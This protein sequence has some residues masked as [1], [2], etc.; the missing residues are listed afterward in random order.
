MT[1]YLTPHT[2]YD[3]VWAFT[4]EDY[5][6]IHELILRKAVEMI[7]NCGYKFLVEQAFLLE[8]I[9]QRDPELFSAIRE[10][11][12]QGK[13]EIVDGQ[14]IMADP[15]IPDGEVL[16]RE[17]MTGKRY[18]K[19]KFG[20]DV[21]VAWASDG[22]GLNAQLP[23]I[24]KKCGYRWLAFR[25]GLPST[26]GYRVSEFLWE[27]LD[28]TQIL[29]HWMPLG[30]RAGMDLEKWEETFS[31]LSALATTDNILM[32]CGSGG[33]PPQDRTPDKVDKWNQNHENSRMVIATPREFFESFERD[34]NTLATYRGELYSPDLENIFPDVVSTRTSLKVAIK[35]SENS[36][37]MAE[38]LAAVARLQGKPYPAERMQ[39]MWKKMLFLAHHDV[40]PSCGID[41][42]YEEAWEYI[43]D[44]KKDSQEVTAQAVCS[45][46]QIKKDAGGT[47]IVVANPNDWEVTS[48]VEADVELDEGYTEEPGL[49]FREQEIPCE[50]LNLDRG[51]DGARRRCRLGF[52]ATVP[53]TGYRVFRLAE[54][55][56]PR[57]N[58]IEFRDRR[59]MTP[60]FDLEVNPENGILQVWNKEGRQI[61]RGNEIVIDEEI[62]DLYFHHS[63][64]DHPIGSESGG[65]IRF[66]AF[67]P[68]EFKIEQGPLRTVIT[69]KDAF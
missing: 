65:G 37:L 13:I 22:F 21:P 34:R 27:G 41:E 47:G 61:L 5:L 54:K 62:G 9:E 45:L 14:Y 25:R 60:Y 57:Q 66:A 42:I 3:V 15:M 69:F 2:H 6:Q 63:R 11:I 38:R 28:G 58:R 24:Y 55:K 51:K 35:E 33:V 32:P 20:V 50:I 56:E 19:E 67:K 40:M 53:P 8:Q 46:A 52:I 36:L 10:A 1:I 31:K 64:L 49:R 4:K 16:V 59:V 17:I 23:Q 43:A 29:S 12:A 26:I 39:S 44:L 18:I 68:E 48:W 30:Y 7:R